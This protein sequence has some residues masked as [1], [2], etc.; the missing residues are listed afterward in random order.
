TNG[1]RFHTPQRAHR[2]MKHAFTFVLVLIVGG[3]CAGEGVNLGKLVDD[4]LRECKD[5][6]I[7]VG[8]FTSAIGHVIDVITPLLGVPDESARKEP[9]HQLDRFEFAVSHPETEEQQMVYCITIAKKLET[10]LPVPAKIWLL[11]SLERIGA[12]ESVG[13]ELKL[14]ND[15]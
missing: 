2:L 4:T 12:V 10:E 9:Q 14:L 8:K 7:T 1:F 13:V 5:P 15:P 6:H 3:C 11:K